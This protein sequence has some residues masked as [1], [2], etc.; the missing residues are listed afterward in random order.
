MYGNADVEFE[1]DKVVQT[2]SLDLLYQFLNIK[3]DAF[4][5]LCYQIDEFTK[6]IC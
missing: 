1:L 5:F 6:W 4:F 3:R 2:D